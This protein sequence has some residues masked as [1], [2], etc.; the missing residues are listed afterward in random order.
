MAL[1]FLI[2]ENRR[3]MLSQAVARHIALGGDP[4]DVVEVGDSSDLGLSL[5]DPEILI[6]VEREQRILISADFSTL[7][8][9]NTAS[10]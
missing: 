7:P 9:S 5:K 3:R 6:W 2:D 8:N 4:I 10:H 1:R